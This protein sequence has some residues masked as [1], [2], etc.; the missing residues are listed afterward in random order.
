MDLKKRK[1]SNLDK[2][3]SKKISILRIEKGCTMSDLANVLSVSTQQISKYEKGLNRVAASQ[4]VL[5]ARFFGKKINYFF[6]QDSDLESL[7]FAIRNKKLR[8]LVDEFIEK[9]KTLI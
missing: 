9:A 8:N 6:E 5:I 7:D 1:V 3:I 2:D 4:L